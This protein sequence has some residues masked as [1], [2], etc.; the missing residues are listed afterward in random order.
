LNIS[1]RDT[2]SDAH[3]QLEIS[4][5]ADGLST[6]ASLAGVPDRSCFSP[7]RRDLIL[8]YRRPVPTGQGLLHFRFNQNDVGG[9][10][11]AFLAQTLESAAG[12]S[13][14]ALKRENTRLQP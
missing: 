8:I 1:N 5:G 9:E 10:Q 14:S 13:P 4:S 2:F 6:A 12:R 7:R 11:I 3:R